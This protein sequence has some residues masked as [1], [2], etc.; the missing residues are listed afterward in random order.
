MAIALGNL[1]YTFVIVFHKFDVDTLE[2]KMKKTQRSVN[3]SN[4]KWYSI[5]TH[6]IQGRAML[7]DLDNLNCCIV[8][9]VDLQA[10]GQCH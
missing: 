4:I 1:G 9:D 8:S 6:R 7:R 10:H 5:I 2:K 3:K